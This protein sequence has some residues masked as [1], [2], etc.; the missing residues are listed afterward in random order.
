M[1][2]KQEK[3]ANDNRST[4]MFV[5]VLLFLVFCARLV[6]YEFTGDTQLLVRTI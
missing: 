3:K 2:M 4:N 6:F 1:N 5:G